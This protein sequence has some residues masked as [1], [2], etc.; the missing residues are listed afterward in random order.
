[1]QESEDDSPYASTREEEDQAP[2]V[3]EDLPDALYGLMEYWCPAQETTE[4]ANEC[5]VEEPAANVHAASH[6]EESAHR[7][8]HTPEKGD[9]M[10]SDGEHL[11]EPDDHHI[12]FRQSRGE[13]SLRDEVVQEESSCEEEEWEEE[14]LLQP[15]SP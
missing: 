2:A 15:D 11:P 6:E 7:H 9:E 8:E 3:A 14:S 12:P 4:V 5:R 1:M 13:A 10:R